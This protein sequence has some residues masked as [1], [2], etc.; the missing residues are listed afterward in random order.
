MELAAALGFLSP[1]HSRSS[2]TLCLVSFMVRM[3]RWEVRGLRKEICPVLSTDCYLGIPPT[4][5]PDVYRNSLVIWCYK[6]FSAFILI[7]FYGSYFLFSFSF[8]GGGNFLLFFYSVV[9]VDVRL[10]T[11]RIVSLLFV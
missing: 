2:C 1:L 6:Q 3:C 5:T 10:L 11:I 9:K 8:F 4:P 7:L